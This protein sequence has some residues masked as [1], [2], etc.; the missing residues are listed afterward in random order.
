MC[1]RPHVKYILFLSGLMKLIF[2]DRF[3][4][5]TQIT[6]FIKIRA[7]GTLFHTGGRTNGETNMTNL[8]VAFCNFAN[9]HKN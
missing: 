3:S 2:L 1:I 7:V 8:M 6:N 4:K 5:N 9:A